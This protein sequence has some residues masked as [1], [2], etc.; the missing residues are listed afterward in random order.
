MPA[1]TR[2]YQSVGDKVKLDGSESRDPDGSQI[3]YKWTF[4]SKP[5]NSRARLKDNKTATPSFTPDKIGELLL[6]SK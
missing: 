4:E 5:A 1:T 3:S 2:R 6:F